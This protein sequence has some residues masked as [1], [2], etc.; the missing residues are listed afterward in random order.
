[1]DIETYLTERVDDQIEYFDSNAIQNQKR[2]KLLKG[3]AI[4]CSI[5]TTLAIALT[6]IPDFKGT[7]EH[8]R[9]G[10]FYDCP[11]CLPS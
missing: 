7:D 5:F 11:C 6:L 4:V 8:F 9:I 10:S 2:Y 1:M 3:T